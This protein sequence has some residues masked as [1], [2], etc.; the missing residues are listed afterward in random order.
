MP[1]TQNTQYPYLGIRLFFGKIPC[2]WYFD[3]KSIFVRFCDD[4]FST[5]ALFRIIL[6]NYEDNF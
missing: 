3:P 2:L 1:R 5:F 4:I 6:S